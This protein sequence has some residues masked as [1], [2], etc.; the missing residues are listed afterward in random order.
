MNI[1]L[2]LYRISGWTNNVVT[3]WVAYAAIKSKKIWKGRYL[4]LAINFMYSALIELFSSITA[5]LN[6]NNLFLDY[7]YVPAAFALKTLYLNG[8]HK[9]KKGLR[10][11]YLVIVLF[12]L[13]QAYKALNAEGYK[14][15][16]A[17][18][19]YGSTAFLLTYSLF[20]L[21]FL[22]K[23][24]IY[25]QK[26]RLNP[27][28]WFTATIFCRSF[29]GLIM[30]FLDATSYVASSEMV[31]YVLFISE[32]FIKAVFYFGYYRGIKLLG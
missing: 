10:F 26:L 32:N 19:A 7:L 16:N 18:G 8:E 15:Y 17:I 24:R 13:A 3:I 28:F 23:E 12:A 31:L 11:T 4:F 30:T 27:N 1:P 25:Q 9:S 21:T 5:L 29:L 22:F 2:I 6:F 14:E 20:N